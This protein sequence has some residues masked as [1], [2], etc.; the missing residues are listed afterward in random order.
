MDEK[1][2]LIERV[3]ILNKTFYLKNNSF[4]VFATLLTVS[5]SNQIILQLIDEMPTKLS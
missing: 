1:R 5:T 3:C 4:V 2:M